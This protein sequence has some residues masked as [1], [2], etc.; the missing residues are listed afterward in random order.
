[1]SV[2]ETYKVLSPLKT[3]GRLY[4]RGDLVPEAESW[5]YA[6]L[7]QRLRSRVLEKTIVSAEEYA[8]HL[9]K[10][11]PEDEAVS[12]DESASA[13]GVEGSSDEAH[14]KT[15]G[16]AVQEVAVPPLQVS[17]VVDEP[18][19]VDGETPELDA[20]EDDSEDGEILEEDDELELEEDNE[21]L[22][23]DDEEA[24]AVVKSAKKI[25]RKRNG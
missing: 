2:K 12:V 3:G 15:G 20:E 5:S 18:D 21:E 6:V 10:F 24:P 19:P 13:P 4:N 16:T 11:S 9:A 14:M 8:A 25:V 23:E 7:E 22:E 1:M 17:D